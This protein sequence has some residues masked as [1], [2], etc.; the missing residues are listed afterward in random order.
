MSSDQGWL[1]SDEDYRRRKARE[2]DERTIEELTGSAPS[3]GWLESEE[4]YRERISREA[5]ESRFRELTGSTASQGWLEDSD[6]YLTRIAQDVNRL[7]VAKFTGSMPSQG[8]LESNE[9]FDVRLRKEANERIVENSTGSFPRQDWFEGDYDYRSRIAHEAREARAA[10]GR[11]DPG[12]DREEVPSTH[13]GSLE[14]VSTYSGAGEKG[15]KEANTA[16]WMGIISLLFF[17]LL[18]PV[19]VIIGN[20]AKRRLQPTSEAYRTAGCGVTLGW[21]TLTLLLG[22]IL[23]LSIAITLQGGLR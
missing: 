7:T 5:N 16:L 15:D 19:A 4:S 9:E 10:Q 14:L 17:P 22:M 18:A 8:W 2:A 12:S 6:S 3:Q 13:G 1:E 11:S 23:F 20:R 21:F